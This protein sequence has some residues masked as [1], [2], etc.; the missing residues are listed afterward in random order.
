MQIKQVCVP[1]LELGLSLNREGDTET[2][3]KV[4]NALEDLLH[5]LNGIP[6]EAFSLQL[7][8]Y[9]FF[10]LSHLLKI[11]NRLDD[12]TLELIIRALG[13]LI[14][15]SWG[16]T[17]QP[18]MLQQLMILIVHLIEPPAADKVSAETKFIS[19]ETKKAGA[20]ALNDLFVISASSKDLQEFFQSEAAIPLLGHT[21]LVLLD[22]ALKT[23]D[24]SCSQAAL[25]ALH[26][27]LIRVIRDGEVSASFLPG[28]VSVLC[29][30]MTPSVRKSHF[31]LLVKSLSLFGRVLAVTL[32]DSELDLDSTSPVSIV[33]SSTASTIKESQTKAITD[34]NESESSLNKLRPEGKILRTSSWVKATSTQIIISL[35]P[36]LK[37]RHHHRP[38]VR[39]MVYQICVLLLSH[40]YI[41]LE[42]CRSTFIILI[43][44]L[45]TDLDA[46]V[47][48]KSWESLLRIGSTHVEVQ[49]AVKLALYDWLSRI[50]QTLVQHDD[51]LKSQTLTQMKIAFELLLEWNTELASIEEILVPC[52]IASVRFTDS[53]KIVASNTANLDLSFLRL[54]WNFTLVTKSSGLIEFSASNME[55][56]FGKKATL[57]LQQVL[58]TV[59]GS[60]RLQRISD[61]CLEVIVDSNESYPHKQVALWMIIHL[62][63]GAQRAVEFF[64]FSDKSEFLMQASDQIIQSSYEVLQQNMDR[65]NLSTD[66]VILTK[67]SLE[68]LSISA[69]ILRDDFQIA[70]IDLLY[71]LL[72]LVISP[73]TEVRQH[74]YI[75]LN[76][77]AI[78]TGYGSISS[79]LIRN[80]DYILDTISLKINTLDISPRS[81]RI[82]SALIKLGGPSTIAYLDDITASIFHLLDNYHGYSR[83]VEGFFAV[84]KAVVEE[85]ALEAMAAQLS[86]EQGSTRREREGIWTLDALINEL[87]RKPQFKLHDSEQ[88]EDQDLD[89]KTKLDEDKSLDDPNQRDEHQSDQSEIWDSPI[90]QS[91]Y[92]ILK[93]ICLLSRYYLSHSSSLLRFQLLDLLKIALSALAT[94]PKEF[95]PIINDIWPSIVP[96]VDDLEL[97]VQ[98]A[99]LDVISELCVFGADFMTTR[100][101]AI[102][103]KLKRLV[104]CEIPKSH[105]GKFSRD[106]QIF[107]ATM[108]CLTKIV[109]ST[110]VKNTVFEELLD[111]VG[112]FL[113]FFPELKD[114]L[115]LVSSDAVWVYLQ[116]A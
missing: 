102:W 7:G 105:E 64:D 32:N 116:R 10:P 35:E 48:S 50:Q 65:D 6:P 68:A 76:N 84:L 34:S 1:L 66:E 101:E 111:C 27:L 14:T 44:S 89:L 20:L 104:P 96:C 47:A 51:D 79:L 49:E 40:C 86:I 70:L 95:L 5:A 45:A 15:H 91:S 53:T 36:V 52:Y 41:S 21:V 71:P 9:I 63:K 8:D 90:P 100:I 80:M 82:L 43:I 83:L 2:K 33:S 94:C 54:D 28:V 55:G 26:T 39:L 61:E 3:F 110:K 77:I 17:L 99:S 115:E 73:L 59:G 103:P 97:H 23:S 58:E 29:K 98:I 108:S 4:V 38:E 72:N 113:E 107:R 42:N 19:N 12:R 57:A 25:D 69:E 13:I 22:L 11:S 56:V 78:H 16:N 93:R 31:Q 114:A 67:L 62:M 112:P 81:A 92:T 109:K 106:A 88:T 24:D 37:L 74:T 75:A 85:I 60:V 87:E 46:E 18:T 30:I